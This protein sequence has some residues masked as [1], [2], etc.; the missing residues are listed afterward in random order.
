MDGIRGRKIGS[1]YMTLVGGIGLASL[2]VCLGLL[3]TASLGLWPDSGGA[4]LSFGG[5]PPER[6]SS[7]EAEN[8]RKGNGN[9]AAPGSSLPPVTSIARTFN[10]G[11]SAGTGDN[12][13]G[14]DTSNEPKRHKSSPVAP[15][16]R[17]P[18]GHG[19][20]PP[21]HGG[22]PPGHAAAPPGH[23]ATPPGHGGTPPGHAHSHGPPSATRGKT[24]TMHV[25]GSSGLGPP[26]LLKK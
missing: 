23:A 26:G 1:T 24:A 25:R 22:T 2:I 6:S 15:P 19:G 13:G 14:R 10:A 17:T 11:A 18:P 16:A 9:P 3:G 4:G 12:G 5:I 21:G 20:T 8:K 7:S